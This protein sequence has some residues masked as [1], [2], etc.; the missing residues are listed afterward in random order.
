MDFSLFRQAMPFLNKLQAI[1]RLL[2]RR[3]SLSLAVWELR[4][5]GPNG[6]AVVRAYEGG[7]FESQIGKREFSQPKARSMIRAGR[8]HRRCLMGPAGDRLEEFTAASSA[9]GSSC[10][11]P[12]LNQG[13]YEAKLSL[14][15]FKTVLEADNGKT[16]RI[17]AAARV[18]D[19]MGSASKTEKDSNRNSKLPIRS[20]KPGLSTSLTRWG[21]VHKSQICSRSWHGSRPW[22]GTVAWPGRPCHDDPSGA[23]NDRAV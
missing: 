20:E 2:P 1:K 13:F 22:E 23:A 11:F 9:L 8:G 15:G 5:K 18:E 21:Q 17:V 6:R 14:F 19:A 4:R 7:V 16:G 3:N 10:Y 12:P